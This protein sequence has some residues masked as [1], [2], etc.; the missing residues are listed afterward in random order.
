MWRKLTV[1]LMAAA[2]LGLLALQPSGQA[3]T[4]SSN[5][6]ADTGVVAG[7]ADYQVGAF[8]SEDLLSTSSTAWQDVPGLSLDLG[9]LGICVMNEVSTTVSVGLLGAPAGFRVQIDDARLQAPGE[10]RFD[11]SGGN[12]SF[13]YTFADD[14]GNNPDQHD[15]DLQWRSPTGRRVTLVRGSLNGLFQRYA[16]S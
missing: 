2:T 3:S 16:C 13:N 7:Y 1:S 6:P 9:V 8:R 14:V 4:R 12:P 5:A 10:I 11:P 15:F